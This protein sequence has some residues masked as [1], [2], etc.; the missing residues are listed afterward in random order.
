VSIHLLSAPSVAKSAKAPRRS[1]RRP[2][3]QIIGDLPAQHNRSA[4]I[5]G[6]LIAPPSPMSIKMSAAYLISDTALNHRYRFLTRSPLP[7]AVRPLSPSTSRR[8]G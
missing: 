6:R 1:P 4:P 2:D 8:I 7:L 3:V 5:S